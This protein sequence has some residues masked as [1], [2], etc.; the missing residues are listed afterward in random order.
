MEKYL[1][2]NKNDTKVKRFIAVDY[3]SIKFCLQICSMLLHHIDQGK[4]FYFYYIYS[5]L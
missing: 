4:K 3:F 5:L 2:I 1:D